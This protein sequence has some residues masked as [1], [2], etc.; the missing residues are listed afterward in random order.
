MTKQIAPENKS[1]KKVAVV[2]LGYVGLPL[3]LLVD[4]RGYE[5]IGIDINEDKVKM[6]ND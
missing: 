5:A 1:K 4:R 6:L 2:G 3:A